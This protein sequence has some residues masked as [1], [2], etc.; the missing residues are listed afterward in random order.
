MRR[1]DV[2]ISADDEW[3]LSALADQMAAPLEN[4][5]LAAKIRHAALLVENARLYES[6]REARW[7]PSGPRRG[8]AQRSRPKRRTGE[9]RV[10]RQHEPRASHAAQ[11]DRRLRRTARDGAARRLTEAQR[12]DLRRIQQNQ[13]VLLG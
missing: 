8:G 4:A 12:E 13:R 10:H 7:T 9:E 5:Q 3:L 11:R 2:E 6:E 1:S